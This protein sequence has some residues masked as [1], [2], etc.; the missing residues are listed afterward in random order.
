MAAKKTSKVNKSAFV[1]SLPASLPAKEVV[2]RAKAKGIAISEKYVA[3]ARYNARLAQK[4][5][6]GPA[7]AA[8]R[9]P[10]RP[11]AAARPASAPSSSSA[12]PLGL[13]AAIDRIVGEIVERKVT[14]VLRARWG[15]LL[16]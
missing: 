1:R 6:G 13:A 16:K 15:E 8:K 14:E 10:G 12:A 5:K 11:P 7:P 3:T 4:K 2:A 9:G